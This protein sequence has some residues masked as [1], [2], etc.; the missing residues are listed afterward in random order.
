MLIQCTS[1]S[2]MKLQLVLIVYHRPQLLPN[3]CKLSI[4]NK[5]FACLCLCIVFVVCQLCVKSLFVLLHAFFQIKSGIS[6]LSDPDSI[7][8]NRKWNFRL[9]KKI[10]VIYTHSWECI[11]YS[12][13]GE[14]ITLNSSKYTGLQA[15]LYEIYPNNAHMYKTHVKKSWKFQ[16]SL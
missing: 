1:R 5:I 14:A 15:M 11:N 9:P 16:A 10:S 8:W 12:V 3:D 4:V 13:V 2:V 7:F 6:N